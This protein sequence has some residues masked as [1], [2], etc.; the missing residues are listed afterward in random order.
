MLEDPPG[1]Q[2]IFYFLGRIIL[3]IDIDYACIY[4]DRANFVVNLGC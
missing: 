1:A 3:P 2:M 4:Y